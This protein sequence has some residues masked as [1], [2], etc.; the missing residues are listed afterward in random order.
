MFG[1]AGQK[2]IWHSQV[3]DS[4]K[5]RIL[6]NAKHDVR[7]DKGRKS[8]IGHRS[9]QKKRFSRRNRKEGVAIYR[10]RYWIDV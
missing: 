2:R 10:R 1:R 9:S 7:R 6:N 4:K 3:T 8:L 5:N